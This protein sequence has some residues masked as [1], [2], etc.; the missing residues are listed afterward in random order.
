MPSNWTTVDYKSYTAHVVASRK[1]LCAKRFAVRELEEGGGFENLHLNVSR[2]CA[3][4]T[5][6]RR[7]LVKHAAA[8]LAISRLAGWAPCS[9]FQLMVRHDEHASTV[10]TPTRALTRVRRHVWRRGHGRRA[11]SARATATSSRPEAATTC[12]SNRAVTDCTTRRIPNARL[13][14]V[15][16][17][18][19][20]PRRAEARPSSICQIF[21]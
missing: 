3:K 8:F 15:G 11:R 2:R 12:G 17:L 1:L 21:N 9:S 7:T 6:T 16:A 20:R 5:L 14:A 4:W 19:R 13:L 10:L 18:V